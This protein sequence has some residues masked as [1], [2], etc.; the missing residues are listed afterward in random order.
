MR[1]DRL[2]NVDNADA[3]EIGL[4]KTDI[5]I[6]I[7]LNIVVEGLYKECSLLE[8]SSSVNFNVKLPCLLTQ[9]H[10]MDR[11]NPSQ[12]FDFIYIL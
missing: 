9:I 11:L 10:R 6:L 3:E 5:Q 2:E 12:T 7:F 4:A 1:R 8:S